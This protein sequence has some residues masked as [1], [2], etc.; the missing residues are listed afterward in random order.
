MDLK[1]S[2][3]LLP[4]LRCSRGNTLSAADWLAPLAPR[5]MSQGLLLPIGRRG[6]ALE[7]IPASL[8]SGP[9]CSLVWIEVKSVA[10]EGIQR[11]FG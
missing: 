9:W 10:Q 8:L 5:R 6:E 2:D 1:T 3:Y 4:L 7:L 11:T